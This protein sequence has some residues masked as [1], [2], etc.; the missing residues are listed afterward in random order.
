MSNIIND[1]YSFIIILLTSFIVGPI[2]STSYYYS[3]KSDVSSTSLT[4]Y[5]CIVSL[6]IALIDSVLYGISFYLSTQTVNDQRIPINSHK[7]FQSIIV[8][9][10]QLLKPIN[11]KIELF[12]RTQTDLYSLIKEIINDNHTDETLIENTRNKLTTLEFLQKD[13]IMTI[14]ENVNKSLRLLK[15]KSLINKNNKLLL[16][17]D[18]IFDRIYLF[19]FTISLLIY[20]HQIV[21][22]FFQYIALKNP[23]KY[24]FIF[25]YSFCNYSSSIFRIN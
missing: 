1:F 7:H 19:I 22:W 4:S 24:C 23:K 15:N 3:I 11:E 2:C 16:H 21:L 5:G 12:L 6:T 8:Q 13:S 9:E 25:I 14:Q 17:N 18:F 10:K 20:I